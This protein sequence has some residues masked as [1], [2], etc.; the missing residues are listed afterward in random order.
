MAVELRC[1]DCRAKLK[2]PEAPEEG[3]EVECPKCGAA[4]PAPEPE[5]ADADAPKR[6]KP[7]PDDDEDERPRKDEGEKKAKKAKKKEKDK[8]K[9]AAGTPK[10]R[11]AKKKETSNVAL[12]AVIG[13]G[14]LML[15]GVAGTLIWFFARTPKSVEMMT[16]LPEDCDTASGL[17]LGHAQKYPEMYKSLSGTFKDAEFKAAGDALAKALVAA[18]A[19][20][21]KLIEYVVFGMSKGPVTVIRTKSDFDPGA[22]SKLPG[23]EAKTL[24]GKTYYVASPFKGAAKVRVFAPTSRLVVYSTASTA[25]LSDAAFQ[26]ML[27]GHAA[28]K[29][30]TI[31]VRAEGLAKRVTK[32]TF[33]VLTMYDANNK[34]PVA[35][36]AP[37]AGSPASDD[38][39]VQFAQMLGKTLTGA[40]GQ[41]FKASV[42][43]REVRFEWVVWSADSD[44]ASSTSKGFKESD[45]GKGDDG[46]PPRWWKERT[47]ALGNKKIA[48]QLL[49]NIGFGSSGELFYAKSAV[50]SADM[51]D[52]VSTMANQATGGN[53]N[54]P[55]GKG[56]RR[57]RFLPVRAGARR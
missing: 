12:F 1:P 51:K 9:D 57:R 2:L 32:G 53:P 10:R 49:T 34:P 19:D 50:E 44:K 45:L 56:P 13:F 15:A 22:L 8:G 47:D 33:W 5:A 36:A 11:K 14:V 31:G 41:G 54:N 37:A 23:A 16:Y 40:K 43:S 46:T 21:D 35:P 52:A 42:G 26:K 20:A 6:K 48:A 27:D 7:A 4:F 39:A 38:P 18:D 55:Q 17:N 28:S 3:T 30:K 29:D 24:G 25:E